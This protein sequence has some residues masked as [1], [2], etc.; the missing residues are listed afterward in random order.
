MP[1]LRKVW[2][3]IGIQ[4]RGTFWWC[5]QKANIFGALIDGKKVFYQWYGRL[6]AHAFLEFLKELIAFLPEDKLYVFILDNAPA[7][8]AKMIQKYL[9]SLGNRFKIEFL[10]TYS[11][12][13]NAIETCWKIV[14]HNVTNS[15]LF[16]TIEHLKKGVEIFLDEYFFML[17]STNYLVR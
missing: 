2:A 14:R 5:N 17:N 10:P 4:P 9:A 6:N 1:F 3:P 7:H 15:N 8:R 13:L 16:D 12:E 11:P